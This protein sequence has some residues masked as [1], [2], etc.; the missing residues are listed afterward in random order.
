[1]GTMTS[2]GA[3][4]SVAAFMA[5][6][7][8]GGRS[9]VAGI[10]FVLAVGYAYGITRANVT[11][12]FAYFL[13]DAAVIGLFLARVG[14]RWTAEQRARIGAL[15]K[16]VAVL[17][18]CPTLLL[19][20]PAQDF[21]I[22]LVGLRGN[23][24]LLPFILFGA[25]LENTERYRLALWL[26]ALNVIAFGF[27]VAEFAV[28][29]EPF[30]PPSPVT[31][32]IYRS[33][34]VTDYTALRIPAIF[35]SAHAFAGTM[36]VSIPFLFGAWVQPPR[37]RWHQ[38]L[39]GA[40]IPASLVGVFMAAARMHMVVAFLIAS[41]ATFAVSSRSAHRLGWLAAASVV[42]W[43]VSTEV[44]FQRFT[45]LWEA[46]DV[47]ERIAGSV[48][49]TFLEI[50][51]EFPFGNGL[52]GGGTSIPQFL[53]S[54]IDYPVL[55]ENEYSRILLELGLPGLALWLAFLL[56]ILTRRRAESGW[57][58]GHRLAWV[59]AAAY[60]GSALIGTG[61][62]TSIPQTCLFLMCIG[63]VGA[64]DAPSRSAEHRLAYRRRGLESSALARRQ[65]VDP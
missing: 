18:I 36:V 43:V 6:F 19:L 51:Q 48:N 62:L 44:R 23:A 22:Q 7:L 32:L 3:I 15:G 11:D 12:F 33:H 65:G 29:L 16:W 63:W 42:V 56:W 10:A 1:M 55:L 49:M 4:L 47:V 25:A 21:L 38:W 58:I 45:T 27:A 9:L 28:G 5:A 57:W 26:A 2:F 35:G 40:A 34:A 37:R 39:L 41:F 20:V 64:H 17:L 13:F 14:V 59:S 30:F 24:L 8:V 61:L 53:Q 46:E 54:R 60:V 50:A 31:D 52:G